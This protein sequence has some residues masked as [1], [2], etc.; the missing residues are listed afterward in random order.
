MGMHGGDGSGVRARRDFQALA[1]RRKQAARLFA[2]G[3][4]LATVARRLQVSRQSVSRWYR[5]WK[6]GGAAALKS[7]GRAGRAPRV[8]ATELR[9]VERALREGARANGFNT[10]LWTLPR[11]AQVIERLTGVKYH[12]GHVWRVMRAMGWTLQRPARRAKERNEEAIRRWVAERWPA[13]KKKPA[14]STPG[15][16]SKTK[17]GSPSARRSGAPGRRAAKRPS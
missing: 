14:A 12:A 10:D 6:S 5:Q 2:E 9:Q 1:Q 15:L 17:A 13:V 4:R 16:P 7:A 11:V 8:N 3:E